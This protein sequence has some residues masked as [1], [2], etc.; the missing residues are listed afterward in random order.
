[1]FQRTKVVRDAAALLGSGARLKNLNNFERPVLYRVRR[2][3]IDDN[4]FFRRF[5][6]TRL[7][8]TIKRPT[9][10]ANAAV[11]RVRR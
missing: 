8:L 2:A 11:R 6:R 7:S 10:P 5:L 4:Q 9:R 3:I 1:M